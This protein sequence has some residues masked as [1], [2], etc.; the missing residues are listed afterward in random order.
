M[1]VLRKVTFTR[2]EVEAITEAALIAEA[3]KAI[4]EP[5]PAEQYDVDI[6]SYCESYVT[7]KDR[8]AVT[9]ETPQIPVVAAQPK[10]EVPL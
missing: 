10:D 6:S 2:G 1:K 9:E 5:N 7:I 4:G 8:K 3:A